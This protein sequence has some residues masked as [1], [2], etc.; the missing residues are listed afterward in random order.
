M[1]EAELHILEA[2]MLDARMAKAR[3]GEL[4]K[5]V[6]MGYVRR[7]S[8]EIVLDPDEQAQATIRLVFDLYERFGTIGKVLRH[9]ADHGIRRPRHPDAGS[10]PGWRKQG[11]T[12]MAAA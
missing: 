3:R 4:G 10:C 2:R 7:P 5:P 6:P 12:R 9:L 11:G 1:S 8:G